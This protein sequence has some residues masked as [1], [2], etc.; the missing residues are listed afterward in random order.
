MA[1]PIEARCF[2]GT[3]DIM[4]EKM[5]PRQRML[6]IITRVF[7]SYGFAPLETPTME[8]LDILLAKSGEENAK[9]IYNLAYK[10]GNVL[11]LRF[12]LTV[13]LA[14]C[15]AMRPDLPMPFRRYQIQPVFRGERAQMAQGRYRE[16]YQCDVDTLG[17]TSMTADAE[18]IAVSMEVYQALGIGA[19]NG[20]LVAR[21]NNRK[22]LRAITVASGL[23]PEMDQP[24]CTALDKIDKI[25]EA[26]V[27]AELAE[28]GIAA[29]AQDRLF[30]LV[31]LSD[32]IGRTRHAEVL[33]ALEGRF[34]GDPFGLQ[35]LQ[36]VREVLDGAE[37]LG[38]PRALMEFDLSLTR[39]M[40][41][42][43]GPIY[44]FRAVKIPNFGS[45][46]GGGRYDDLIGLYCGRQVPATGVSVGLS[47]VQDALGLLGLA[48]KEKSTPA[49]AL[50]L[51]FEDVPAAKHLA[52]AQTLRRDG[53]A[54]E[55]YCEPAKF[56][57]QIGYAEKKGIPFVVVQGTT[58][59]EKGTAQVKDLAAHR[60]EEMPVAKI[61]AYIAAASR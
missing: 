36:E 27:R 59:L 41:Y 5:I 11:G 14:R 2:K 49:V 33:A 16:F 55:I 22:I 42:Y 20:G 58:E 8:F 13:P 47:R 18:N 44:E 7:E 46:G 24:V 48:P 53:L 12:D 37:A 45:L 34:Q 29:D 57:K 52:L 54:T 38:V 43:T 23:A 9:L 17:T 19:D 15:V 6:G 1:G 60:Q 28:K 56:K 4:P 61:A 31:T 30:D 32:K 50:I 10:G 35:G 25:G 39:G 21:V 40:D 51:R 3:E 26:L